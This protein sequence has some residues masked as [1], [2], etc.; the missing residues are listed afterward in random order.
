MKKIKTYTFHSSIPEVQRDACIIALRRDGFSANRE[1]DTFRTDATVL[2]IGLS[3]GTTSIID[4]GRKG[5]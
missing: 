5:N 1:V 4:L 3:W 2:G